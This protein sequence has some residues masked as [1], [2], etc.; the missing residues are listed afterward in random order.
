MYE[1][2]KMTDDQRRDILRLRRLK[3]FPLHS[4]PH[5][6]GQSSFYHISSACYNHQSFIGLSE[7]RILEF[8]GELFDTLISIGCKIFAWC[9]LPNHFHVLIESKSIRVCIKNIGLL[10]GR[11]SYRWNNEENKRG[12]KVWCPASDRNIRSEGHFWATI[13]YIHHNPVHHRYVSHWQEW[14][15]S[16]A[17]EFLNRYGHEKATELWNTYPIYDYGKGWDDPEI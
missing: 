14:P 4:P 12:R 10:H 13:N 11:T 1:W 17:I 9:V 2:R 16:S 8:S 15:F 7:T 3:G 6:L 5:I